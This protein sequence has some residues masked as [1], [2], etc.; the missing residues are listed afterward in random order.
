MEGL[1]EGMDRLPHLFDTGW[2]QLYIEKLNGVTFQLSRNKIGLNKKLC[3]KQKNMK[4]QHLYPKNPPEMLPSYVCY[5]DILGFSQVSKEA[6]NANKG[7]LFLSKLRKALSKAYTRLR[8]N[9]KGLGKDKFYSVKVF[10]DNIVVGY[11]ISLEDFRAG[12]AEL[13]DIFSTFSEFQL[14]LALEGFL[15]RGSIAFGKHYMDNDIVFGDALLEAVAQDKQGGAP[16]ISL[17]RSA[18][19]LLRHHLGSY[20]ETN[21]TPQHQDLLKDADGIIFLNYLEEA[22]VAFPDGGI[23]FE[24]IEGHRDIIVAGLKKFRG[25]PG[26]RSKYEWAAR[27]HNFVCK[28]FAETHQVPSNP[29]ADE[30]YAYAA[31]EAQDLLKY[32]VDIDSLSTLPS[33]IM[34]EPKR[35][36]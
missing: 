14:S 2:L 12:E 32:L 26:V 17:A 27:Y 30:M 20:G 13:C 33:R 23:F 11:P 22:F 4:K 10:T 18:V 15:L 24:Y 3:L 19:K 5:A 25:N 36:S 8:N 34:F 6:L 21:W 28:E 16:C 9:A 1:I 31:E 35:I 7:N 29:D